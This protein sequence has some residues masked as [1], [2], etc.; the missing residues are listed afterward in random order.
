M[1]QMVLSMCLLPRVSA[2]GA[3]IALPREATYGTLR[4]AHS[5]VSQSVAEPIGRFGLSVICAAGA[6]AA[7]SFPSWG[8]VESG[9]AAC[10]LAALL[11]AGCLALLRKAGEIAHYESAVLACV[12]CAY[13]AAGLLALSVVHFASALVVGAVAVPA[14][15]C[16]AAACDRH[17]PW[18]AAG[19]AALAWP[20][21]TLCA[22]SVGA[23]CLGCTAETHGITS[24]G[25]WMPA[26]MVLWPV[27][28]A[29]VAAWARAGH[30]QSHEKCVK[31]E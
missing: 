26:V 17:S 28:A 6:S 9:V 24:R 18:L 20:V 8:M 4:T 7:P 10:T 27:H 2:V 13:A 21:F 12:A 23:T 31:I 22:L 14:C 25:I 30:P 15:L 11:L 3:W 19:A 1:L 5:E 16:L 29:A